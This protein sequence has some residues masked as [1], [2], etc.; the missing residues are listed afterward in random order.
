MTNITTVTAK[1][2][3][4]N[5][6]KLIISCLMKYNLLT[7]NTIEKKKNG[8]PIKIAW[9]KSQQVLT[10]HLSHALKYDKPKN[11]WF[12]ICFGTSIKI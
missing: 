11:V 10:K 12:K 8:I 1:K 9:V 3:K 2:N 4:K 7:W 6:T 5:L